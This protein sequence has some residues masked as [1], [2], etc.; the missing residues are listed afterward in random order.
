MVSFS[1][2]RPKCS[3]QAIEKGNAE[4]V[5]LL[6]AKGQAL[7]VVNKQTGDTPITAAAKAGNASVVRALIDAGADLT[8]KTRDDDDGLALIA[9]RKELRREF[10]DVLAAHG[11]DTSSPASFEPL[12]PA[13][14]E[15]LVRTKVA[16][17]W[18]AASRIRDRLLTYH[19]HRKFRNFIRG[20]LS[21]QKNLRM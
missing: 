17:F 1:I 2:L 8:A 15:P 5:A 14:L 7:D 21:A 18:A 6:C 10:A 20:I 16:L 9:R 11:V 19:H 13:L 12:E 4:V 3:A